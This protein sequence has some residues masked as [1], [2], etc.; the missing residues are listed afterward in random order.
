MPLAKQDIAG[1]AWCRRTAKLVC[2]LGGQVT[3][4][5][6]GGPLENGQ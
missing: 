3:A 4:E 5:K 2:E 1:E 6:I